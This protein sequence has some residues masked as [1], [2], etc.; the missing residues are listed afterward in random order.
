[1]KILITRHG[2]TDWNVLGKLQGQ[3]DIELNDTGRMQAENIKELVK[4]EKIDLI[5]TSPLKRAK[6]TALIINQDNNIPIIEDKRLMERYFGEFE[7]VTKEDRIKLRE[8]NLEIKDIWNYK[9]NI[10]LNTMENM[11]DF[12][13]RIYNFLDEVIKIYKDRNILIVTHGGASVPI[14]CYFEKYPLESITDRNN[15]KSLENCEVIKFEI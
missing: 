5:I 11:H 3:T 8:I 1:M 14:I 15:I 2:Q 4:N 12:C 7:G 9:K 13:S 6:E 10:K